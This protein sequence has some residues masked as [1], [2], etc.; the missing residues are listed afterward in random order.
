MHVCST[1]TINK[2]IGKK[3]ER[4]NRERAKPKRSMQAHIG[5]RNEAP[6]RPN[7]L[8]LQITRTMLLRV[9]ELLQTFDTVADA[10]RQVS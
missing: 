8:G 7:K 4:Y 3:Y 9:K 2:A 10:T 5:T 1:P 6:S